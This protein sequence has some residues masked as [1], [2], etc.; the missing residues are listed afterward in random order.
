MAEDTPS[1]ELLENIVERLD[2]LERILQTQTARIYAVEQRLGFE[3]R[4][5]PL[6]IEQAERDESA[7]QQRTPQ[8]DAGAATRT[9]RDAWPTH[10]EAGA[11]ENGAPPF[12]PRA[13]GPR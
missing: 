12:E 7:T 6:G 3:P 9:R 4:P 11:T 2:H 10:A 8:D 5:R 13:D 1:R